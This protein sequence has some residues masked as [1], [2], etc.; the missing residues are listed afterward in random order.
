[1][2]ASSPCLGLWRSFHSAPDRTVI[3]VRRWAI[4]GRNSR[5][6]DL[7]GPTDAGVVACWGPHGDDSLVDRAGQAELGQRARNQLTQSG[8]CV[9][10][11]RLVSVDRYVNLGAA[12]APRLESHLAARSLEPLSR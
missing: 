5:S 7:Y 10:G 12:G 4:C 2:T 1:V 11:A 9:L 6:S 3:S 8:L